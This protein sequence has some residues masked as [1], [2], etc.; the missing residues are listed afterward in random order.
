LPELTRTCITQCITRGPTFLMVSISGYYGS[1]SVFETTN[2]GKHIWRASR[3]LD[4]KDGRRFITGQDHHATPHL[5]HLRT[6]SKENRHRP[7]R[8]DQAHPN[9][10]CVHGHLA[11]TRRHTSQHQEKTT[12]RHA[13]THTTHDERAGI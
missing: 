7:H 11:T 1:R 9:R 3:S 13:N 4:A 6:A 2:H 10:E 12:S 5:K 8:T